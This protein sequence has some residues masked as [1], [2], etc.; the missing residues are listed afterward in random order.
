MAVVEADDREVLRLFDADGGERVQRS[1]SP[2]RLSGCASA[3]SS[4][5]VGV[6]PICSFGGFVPSAFAI[7]G[8]Q[9]VAQAIAQFLD[10]ARFADARLTREQYDLA[11]AFLCAL[12]SLEQERDFGL[13]ANQRRQVGAVQRLEAAVEGACTD[14]LPHRH[15]LAEAFD[16]HAPESAVFEEVAEEAAGDVGDDHGE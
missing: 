8:V 6:Q 13:T 15:R 4:P 16:A 3:R 1:P 9:F 7:P 14:N 11:V 5:T 12:P 2:S 10:D